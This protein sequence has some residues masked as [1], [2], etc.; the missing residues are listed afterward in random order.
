MADLG[1]FLQ[2]VTLPPEMHKSPRQMQRG[3]FPPEGEPTLRERI[4]AAGGKSLGHGEYEDDQ[5][6]LV[7]GW[8][9]RREGDRWRVRHEEDGRLCDEPNDW[10][11]GGYGDALRRS[12]DLNREQQEAARATAQTTT[13]G[14]SDG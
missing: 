1:G 13:K 14:D 6:P 10:P 12:L 2:G 7:L 11:L 4:L 3:S 9:Q 8:Y 5:G